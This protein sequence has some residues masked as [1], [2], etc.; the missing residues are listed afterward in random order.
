MKAASARE[1]RLARCRRASRH[2]GVV[3]IAEA[4]ETTSP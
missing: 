4:A 3:A 2:A 1:K